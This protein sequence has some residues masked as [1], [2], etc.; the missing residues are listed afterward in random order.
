MLAFGWPPRKSLD[1]CP[2]TVT[3]SPAPIGQQIML[4]SPLTRLQ[5]VLQQRANYRQT[6]VVFKI[7]YYFTQTTLCAFLTSEPLIVWRYSQQCLSSP[8][9]PHWWDSVVSFCGTEGASHSSWWDLPGCR[10]LRCPAPRSDLPA[11]PGSALSFP[12]PCEGNRHYVF[13]LDS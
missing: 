8:V 1:F 10:T 2:R 3:R 7:L 9:C 6:F 11:A 4:I 12:R 5:K 13:D